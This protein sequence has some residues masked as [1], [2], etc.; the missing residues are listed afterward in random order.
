MSSIV[1]ETPQILLKAKTL[2]IDE[3]MPLDARLRPL[4]KRYHQ[5]QLPT[6]RMYI[7]VQG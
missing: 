2:L 6:Q 5:L 1:G 3:E 7:I 4:R